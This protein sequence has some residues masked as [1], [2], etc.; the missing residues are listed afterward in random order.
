MSMQRGHGPLAGSRLICGSILAILALIML[1]ACSPS[2]APMAWQVFYFPASQTLAVSTLVDP[3]ESEAAITEEG[4]S[5]IEISV[6]QV[7]QGSGR[8]SCPSPIGSRLLQVQSPVGSR[9][10]EA[11]EGSTGQVFNLATRLHQPVT[12]TTG[13]PWGAH[14]VSS[15]QGQTWTLAYEAPTGHLLYQLTS[16]P[17]DHRHQSSRHTIRGQPMVTPCPGTLCWREGGIL[18]SISPLYGQAD[19]KLL[20]VGQASAL[21]VA[22]Q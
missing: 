14:S 1:M 9:K 12:A 20:T 17:D 5:T 6:H 16:T 22:L 13:M 18:Y 19:P 7:S 15:P 10:I 8:G 11:S 2:G 3:C 21:A 4:D